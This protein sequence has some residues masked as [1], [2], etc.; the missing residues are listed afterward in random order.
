MMFCGR[1]TLDESEDDVD[2]CVLEGGR[3]GTRTKS[4]SDM[5]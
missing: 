2:G 5:I 3:E 4:I 1:W